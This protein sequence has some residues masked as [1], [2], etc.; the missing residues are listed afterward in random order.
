M[1]RAVLAMKAEV[2]FPSLVRDIRRARGLTQEQLA[3]EMNVTFATVNGW[4]NRKHRPIQAFASHL[5]DMAAAA[6]VAPRREGVLKKA[7]PRKKRGRRM[8]R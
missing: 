4:E 3:R 8:R 2:D 7:G 5:L 6:G 1:G